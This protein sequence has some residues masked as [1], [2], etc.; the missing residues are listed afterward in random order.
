MARAL[1][2]LRHGRP[3]IEV[4][5]KL[6]QG[7]QMVT[8]VLLADSGAGALNVPFELILDEVDCLL[9]GGKP[10]KMVQ[11]GGAYSGNHPVYLIVAEIPQLGLVAS[12]PTVGVP[13]PPAGLDGI[14]CFRFLNRFTYGN[15][16]QRDQF[17]LET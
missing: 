3:V 4:E 17:G 2:P 11:L 6:A 13:T 8:R 1:W 9:C 7:G 15:F 10:S 12:L 16:G 5:L 14:A